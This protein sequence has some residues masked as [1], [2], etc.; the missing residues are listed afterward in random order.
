MIP[1]PF[2]AP[3]AYTIEEFNC[4]RLAYLLLMAHTNTTPISATFQTC[5]LFL[6]FQ[7]DAQSAVLIGQSV[8]ENPSFIALRKI[9]AAREIAHTIANSANRVYLPSDS[10]L[11]NVNEHEKDVSVGKRK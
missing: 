10:L 4:I 11:L 9:E 6:N 5:S 8:K 3:F 1:S 2:Y 7:G